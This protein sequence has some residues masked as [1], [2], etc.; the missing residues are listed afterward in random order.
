VVI[1]EIEVSRC[2]A[3]VRST[4][5]SKLDPRRPELECVGELGGDVP[6]TRLDAV[7]LQQRGGDACE[8]LRLELALARVRST[9]ARP[10]SQLADD[11]CSDQVDAEREPVSRIA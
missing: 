7:R 6:H 9:S 5:R 3:R 10:R 11:H 8:E 2:L 1:A 4:Q